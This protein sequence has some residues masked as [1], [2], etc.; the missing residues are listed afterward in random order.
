MV[1]IPAGKFMMGS[2]DGNDDEKPVHTVYVDAFFIDTHEVTVGQY[3]GFVKAT[4]YKKPDWNKVTKFSPTDNHPMIYVSWYDAMAYA[5]WASKRLPTEAEWEYAARAGSAGKKYPWGD[6]IDKSKAN[7]NMG[8]GK[9]T[10]VGKYPPNG[11]GLYD[12]AG[13]VWEWCLDEY[14]EDF[15][16]RSAKEDPIA[17]EDISIVANNF[18]S[19]KTARV[20]RGGSWYGGFNIRVANRGRFNPDGTYGDYGFRCVV[21][22]VQ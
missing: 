15:Y 1:P 21:P 11:Y 6:S 13:N 10:P 16:K 3:R 2:N 7:Y 8:V 22:R 12:M 17:G 20:L 4:G 9:T 5:I 18:I 14:D 19:V